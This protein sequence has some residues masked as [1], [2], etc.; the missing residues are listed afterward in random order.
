MHCV[1]KL[2]TKCIIPSVK[3]TLLPQGSAK[4]APALWKLSILHADLTAHAVY[5]KVKFNC[6][7]H[8]IS[9]ASTKTIVVNNYFGKWA[10]SGDFDL[11]S[12]GGEEVTMR[13]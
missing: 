4:S 2:Y 10:S 8:R 3:C 1:V 13:S 5:F 6:N 9:S 11:F 12:F 7:T